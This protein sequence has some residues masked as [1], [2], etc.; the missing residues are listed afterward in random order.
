[1]EPTATPIARDHVARTAIS[2]SSIHGERFLADEDAEIIER[3][4]TGQAHFFRHP[5]F[6]KRMHARTAFLTRELGRDGA[7]TR[8]DRAL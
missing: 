5:R 8:R 2:A 4:S 1:L 3:P 7:S 6:E